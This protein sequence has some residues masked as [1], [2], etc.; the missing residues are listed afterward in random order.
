LVDSDL[1]SFYWHNFRFYFTKIHYFSL[2][3]GF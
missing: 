2:L 3:I 1:Y